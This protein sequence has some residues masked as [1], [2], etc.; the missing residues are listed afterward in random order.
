M[1]KPKYLRITGVVILAGALALAVG[2][3]LRQRVV[4]QEKPLTQP[5]AVASSGYQSTEVGA[6]KPNRLIDEKSPY[7]LQHAY[8]PVDWYPWG[9][10]AFEK[11][12]KENKPIFLS[13]GYSTCH[14]CHVMERESFSN[15]KIAV[16]MNKHFISIKVDREERPD[17]DHVYMT[18]VQATTGGGGWPM[19]V[20]L[21]PELKPFW[22]GTYFPPDARNGMPG[23]RQILLKVAEQWESNRGAVVASAGRVTEALK[24]L[25][26][27]P[28]DENVK[29]GR[30]LLDRTYQWYVSTY[31]ARNGGFEA[32]PKFPR[33]VNFN[34][35]LRYHARTG[36]K[37]ALEMATHT[38]RKMAD[39]GIHDPIGGGFH[40]Y[41]TDERWFAPHFEKMLY[42]QAQLAI[43][44][45]E[46][47]QLTKEPFFAAVARD[48]FEY[49]LRDM[50][51][52]EGG[53]YSAEDADSPV[54][55]SNRDQQA[56]GAFYV[57]THQ[58]IA[59][60]LG[61]DAAIFEHHYGVRESGN[62]ERDPFGEFKN[63][64]I[65]HVASGLEQ[66]AQR[67]KKPASQIKEILTRGRQTLF[68][69]RAKR[70]RPHPDD[71]VLTAWN[72]LMI[73][74]L[75][76]GYQVLREDR[77]LKA[78]ERAASFVTGRLYDQQ[79][80]LL[81]RRYRKG[82]AAIAGMFDDYAFFTQGLLDLYETSLD[83]RWLIVAMELTETQNRLFWD[84][85]KGGFYNTT[86]KDPSILIRL[87]E[88]Y[89][90]AEPSPNSVA[91]SNLLRLSQMSDNRKWREVADRS[92]KAFGKRLFES[93]QAMPQM[94][95]AVDFHLDKPRQILIA[96][97]RNAPDT[98][99]IVREIH[100]RFIPNKILVLADGGAG[101]QRLAATLD[102][103][104]SLRRI[105][106][107]ATAYICE[108][109]VCHRPTNELAVVVQLLDGKGTIRKRG[110][111]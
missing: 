66:T 5:G 21:T 59:A 52:Q 88:D 77:Y 18:F 82:E 108:N 54:S 81:K 43:S 75:S 26:D 33:P 87:K 65:L 62:V 46:T 102:I 15:P 89:D 99:A 40:R 76:R 98:K 7:L 6:G 55:S 19:S 39:G 27:A 50:T 8:N 13:V 41:S 103:L 79:S 12:R 64:S 56:E 94:M 49:V 57:W 58:E 3:F 111:D 24:N 35:L 84:A 100:R 72:G 85:G 61:N 16:I 42:D 74:A 25:R 110:E 107:K 67:F 9:S 86:E 14:W 95:V 1:R 38:L 105:D 37:K 93:P 20:F 47:Y 92:I 10:A 45:L 91:V 97:D 106:G 53:F 36:Q 4:G 30:E 22:G 83:G 32:A 48:I 23:F 17:I 44:Y 78:A 80:K 69:A 2:L 109:Y 90:G 34:F 96:G 28:G 29:L 68:Q 73:S 60:L 11:A 70:P 51:D 31:G 104:N 101:Q 63:K 71:K